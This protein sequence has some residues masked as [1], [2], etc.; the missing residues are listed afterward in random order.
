MLDLTQKGLL[1]DEE[2]K[3]KKVAVYNIHLKAWSEV[4]VLGFYE[5]NQ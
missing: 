1:L 3:F 2:I 4:S 5:A